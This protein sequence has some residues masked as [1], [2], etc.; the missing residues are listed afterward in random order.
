MRGL[1][2]ASDEEIQRHEED[3][4]RRHGAVRRLSLPRSMLARVVEIAVVLDRAAALEERGA[5]VVV[6]T[7]FERA[8]SPR[9]V[10]IFASRAADRLP[11]V[12]S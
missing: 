5:S 3:T 7:I 4:R 12:A 9:N 10:A 11:R 8:A 1:A 6:A 2:A